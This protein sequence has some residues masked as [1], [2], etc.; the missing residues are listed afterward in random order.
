MANIGHEL[1]I[2]YGLRSAPN[3][4]LSD[5]WVQRVQ[6]LINQGISAEQAGATAA[7]QLF[8]DY[9]TCKYASAADTIESLLGR[10]RNK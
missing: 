1:M 9:E 6:A 3:E 5:Q 4:T 8:P 10:A 2:K 7:R